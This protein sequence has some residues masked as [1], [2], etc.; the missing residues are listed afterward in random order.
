V[1]QKWGGKPLFFFAFYSSDKQQFL[2]CNIKQPGLFLSRI[3]SLSV[4]TRSHSRQPATLELSRLADF[5]YTAHFR[6]CSS[7]EKHH[8][9]AINL[10]S[11]SA[12]QVSPSDTMQKDESRNSPIESEQKII[13]GSQ[14]TAKD[15][16][17][18]FGP[19]EKLFH[20]VMD[21]IEWLALVISTLA[22]ASL[23]FVLGYFNHRPEPGWSHVSLNSLISWISN[24]AK[25]GITILIGSGISQLKWIWFTKREERLSYLQA[26]DDAK[27]PLGAAQLLLA[28]GLK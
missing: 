20:F 18:K 9:E 3:R 16:K 5:Y 28:I 8:S 25:A 10:L 2:R 26:F 12:A 7:M 11:A 15:G 22:F 23:C 14:A 17:S 13:V 1:T 21:H 19:F 27:D 24:V 6:L 4:Y